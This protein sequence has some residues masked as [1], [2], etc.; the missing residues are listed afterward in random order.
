VQKYGGTSMGDT[1]RIQNVAQRVIHY[2]KQGF[3][4]VVTVSAMSGETDRLINLAKQIT[5]DPNERELDMMVSTGEQVSIALLAIALQKLG[6]EAISMNAYQ[7]GIYTDNKHAKAK[8][9]KIQSQRILNELEAGR[10]VI[11][12]GFQGIDEQGDI[13]TLGRGGSDTSAVAIAAALKAQQCEIYTDV[14][15]VYTADPRLVKSAQKLKYITF[16]EM[17]ELAALGAKVL[18]SRSIEFAKKYGVSLVVRSSFSQ[19]EGTTIVKEYKGMENFIVSGITSKKDEA[20]AN[21][22]GLPD[23]PGVAALVFERLAKASVNVNMIAQSSVESEKNNISFTFP[24]SD[25]KV[26]KKVIDDLKTELALEKV[27]IDE[28]IVM[29]SMVGIGMKSNSGVAAKMFKV[30]GDHKINIQMISTSEIKVSV[31]IDKNR[32]DEALNLLHQ[33]FGLDQAR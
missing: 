15:G 31:V 4:V 6:Y 5:P 13:T 3:S 23:Q 22:I 20:K 7:A 28:N 30:L 24:L 25:L 2:K 11:V 21:L 19:E 10:V 17:L 33:E 9:E 18:H 14:D 16:D 32:V 12:A 26:A 1:N 29:L 27:L 8:I